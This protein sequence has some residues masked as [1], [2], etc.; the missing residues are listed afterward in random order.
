MLFDGVRSSVARSTECPSSVDRDKRGGSFRV[1]P[2]VRRS[3]SGEALS[4]AV[5]EV[6]EAMEA[7]GDGVLPDPMVLTLKRL[8]GIVNEIMLSR[9]FGTPLWRIMLCRLVR[10]STFFSVKGKYS[11]K[12]VVISSLGGRCPKKFRSLDGVFFALFVGL[13]DSSCD[14]GDGGPSAPFSGILT[15]SPLRMLI[16]LA[17]FMALVYTSG[18]S[19]A[20][21]LSSASSPSSDT[22]SVGVGGVITRRKRPTLSRVRPCSRAGSLGGA[23][24]IAMSSTSLKGPPVSYVR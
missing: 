17:R 14:V 22:L 7:L 15:P 5:M 1:D 9:R 11:A 13:P 20:R 19:A 6:V 10:S 16:E 3:E 4:T 8:C 21:A 2:S 24:T 12:C 18:G 23:C